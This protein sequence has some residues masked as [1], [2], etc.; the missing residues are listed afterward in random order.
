MQ[1]C[2]VGDVLVDL[3]SDIA[4]GVDIET[5]PQRVEVHEADDVAFRIVSNVGRVTSLSHRVRP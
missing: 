5:I 2:V 4:F 3:D 1:C